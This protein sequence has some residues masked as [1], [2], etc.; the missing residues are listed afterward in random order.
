[1]VKSQELGL[2]ISVPKVIFLPAVEFR[3]L[4]S[5]AK[6]LENGHKNL[7]GLSVIL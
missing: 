2:Y 3:R 1:M 7:F 5:K 4:I 6:E